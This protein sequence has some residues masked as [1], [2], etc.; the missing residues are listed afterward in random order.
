MAGLDEFASRHF[1]YRDLV[2]AGGTFA[3]HQPDNTPQVPE[4]W[5]WLARLAA[6]ILD[7]VVDSFG[8]PEITYGF[9]GANLIRYVDG[10]VV[11]ARDQH[12]G[13]ERD[14]DDQPICV[15]GGQAVD[16]YVP[17]HSSLDVAQFIVRDTD[18][19]QLYFFGPN[20]P[21]HVSCGPENRAAISL[22]FRDKKGD[23]PPLWMPRSQFLR[24]KG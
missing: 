19:D 7:P 4:T 13:F 24:I 14:G 10:G 21:I 5:T 9:A 2:E 22:V 15:R 11:P 16:F 6:G 17:D 3:Q 23:M 1:R 8:W 20:R 18:F 12:A